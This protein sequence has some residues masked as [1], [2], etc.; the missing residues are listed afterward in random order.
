MGR[1]S[2]RKRSGPARDDRLEIAYTERNSLLYGCIILVGRTNSGHFE[3]KAQSKP[4][5]ISETLAPD[6]IAVYGSVRLLID[7][8]QRSLSDIR[9][10]INEFDAAVKGR[11]PATA[12][13]ERGEKSNLATLPVGAQRMH[14]EFSRRLGGALIQLSAQARNLFDLFPRV[15]RRIPLRDYDGKPIGDTALTSLFVHFV[16]NQ[17]LYLNGEHVSDLFPAKPR[18]KAPISQAFMGFK[19]NWITFIE[20]IDRAIHEVRLKDLTELLRSRLKSLSTES[21]YSDIVFLIQNL[22]SFSETLGSKVG[23]ERYRLLDV[24]FNDELQRYAGELNRK[25]KPGERGRVVVQFNAPHIGI[26]PALS[27]KKFDIHVNCQW[28]IRGDD[29]RL[30]CADPDFRRLTKEVGY[31]RF[32]DE[33]ARIFGHDHLC[34]DEPVRYVPSP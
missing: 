20:E 13:V 17:Y 19:F 2:R 25:T 10:L 8:I 29:G 23:D 26:H 1:A 21:P 31:E 33:A 22:R 3:K 9:T 4:F 27:E 5:V 6:E 18:P 12:G 7:D 32:L 14:F 16:H 11:F 24:L 34:P 30:L 28:T 15:D